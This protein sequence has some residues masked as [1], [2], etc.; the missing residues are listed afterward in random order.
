MQ[1][2]YFTDAA[3]FLGATR[4]FR[5][6]EPFLTNVIGSTASSIAAGHRTYE[7]VAFWTLESPGGEVQ[8]AMMRTAPHMLAISP[9]PLDGLEVAA[10]AV[11]EHDP[12][13]PGVSGPREVVDRFVEQIVAKS[14]GRIEANLERGT[15]VYVLGLLSVP[16]FSPGFYRSASNDDFELL[17]R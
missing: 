2:K 1:V 11:P 5:A 10:A 15:L 7:S 4:D 13:V 16:T 8:G 3:E 6:R 17:R 14:D 9:M 12:R